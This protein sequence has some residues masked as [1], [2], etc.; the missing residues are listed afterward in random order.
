M[1]RKPIRAEVAL[2]GETRVVLTTA[3]KGQRLHEGEAVLSV[4]RYS[5]MTAGPAWERK[6]D[7]HF[8][9]VTER[10]HRDGIPFTLETR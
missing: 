4:A 8:S 3:R 1:P 2:E 7:R 5:S 9:A 6:N 10:M